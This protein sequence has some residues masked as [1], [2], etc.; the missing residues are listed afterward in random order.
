[1]G[2]HE[3]GPHRNPVRAFFTV[4]EGELNPHVLS[5]TGT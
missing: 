2:N 1:M 3:E 5:D 4:R